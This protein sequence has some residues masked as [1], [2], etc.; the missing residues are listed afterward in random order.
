MAGIF[1]AV[2]AVHNA[3]VPF[4]V[5]NSYNDAECM[6]EGTNA[7]TSWPSPRFW[8]AP[9]LGERLVPVEMGHRHDADYR[10]QLMSIREL[11]KNLE[12]ISGT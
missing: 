2:H 4:L 6:P 7:F 8:T 11:K 5:K 3:R 10:I 9:P 1:N 12:N